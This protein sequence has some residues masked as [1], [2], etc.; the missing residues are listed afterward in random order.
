M[1]DWALITGASAG[2]GYE[3]ARLFAADRLNLVL[4]ARDEA[5]LKALATRLE[6]EHGIIAKVVV[7]DLSQDTAP[8]ELF[9]SLRDSSI[10]VLVN[11]AGFGWQGG[12]L[13]TELSRSLDMLQVNVDSLVQLCHLFARPMVARG[14]GRIM[15]VASTAAFQPGPFT[16]MYYASKAFVFSFSVAF[17]EELR[18]TGVTV[19]TF[20]PGFTRTEF[21]ERARMIRAP[22]W[23]SMMPAETV[24]RIGYEGTMRGKGIVVPGLL[25]KL[26][27]FVARRLP[28]RFI[29]K[30]VRRINGK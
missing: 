12:F 24:A 6:A 11:N 10:S 13:E 15:N 29:T 20:C 5:R 8:A 21:H 2:I 17:E 26:S 7:K 27:A 22:G 1:N 3:L 16:A 9:D 25:N 28:V 14:S 23:F 18:G 4:V 30:I 19:T